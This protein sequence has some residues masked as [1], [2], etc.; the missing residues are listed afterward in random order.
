M[1]EAGSGVVGAG[2]GPLDVGAEGAVLDLVGGDGVDGGGAAE[3][4][5]AAFG[6][7]DGADLAGAGCSKGG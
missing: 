5:G 7:A 2:T 3:G 1:K 6:E 4:V